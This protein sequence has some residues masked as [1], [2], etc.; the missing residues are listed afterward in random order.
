MSHISN[1]NTRTKPFWRT[2]PRRLLPAAALDAAVSLPG[3]RDL[4]A[5]VDSLIDI[6][7]HSST[8]RDRCAALEFRIRSTARLVEDM[9][10][11]RQQD[12]HDFTTEFRAIQA[13]FDD[14]SCQGH[15][16]YRKA[17]VKLEMLEELDRRLDNVADLIKMRMQLRDL[18]TSEDSR[19]KE[20]N[21]HDIVDQK[22][23]AH[24][25]QRWLDWGIESSEEQLV[26]QTSKRSGRIG[27][28]P[29]MYVAYSSA[30]S[31]GEAEA[32]PQYE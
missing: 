9:P 8:E 5:I 14:A 26:V 1:N 12:V 16:S 2:N 13:L 27:N 32:T 15:R 6:L 22:I 19:L 31:P 21:A 25:S 28:M 18:V 23:I 29:V 20:V 17:A 10:R 4:A 24:P 7:K 3:F 11:L 30:Q